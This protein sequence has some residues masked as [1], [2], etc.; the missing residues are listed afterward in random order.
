MSITKEQVEYVAHLARLDIT[1]E[2]K[3]RFAAQLDSILEYVEKLNEISTEDI[4][5]LVHLSERE[6]VFKDDVPS[7]SLSRKDALAN[8]PEQTEGCFKVPQIL[9]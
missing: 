1:E 5:P 2:E 9:E 3:A 7:G 4:E 6:N 8:A